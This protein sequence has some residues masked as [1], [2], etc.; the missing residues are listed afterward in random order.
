MSEILTIK[1]LSVSVGSKELLNIEQLTASAGEFIA[2]LGANGAGKTTLFKSITGEMRA[3]V[4]NSEPV[5][6]HRKGINQWSSI[7]LA[8]HMAVLPQASQLTFPFTVKE[9]VA[10]GLIPL[11]ASKQE[12]IRLIEDAML[13]TDT[14]QFSER[15]YTQLSGGERQRVHLARVLVQ[16]SQAEE[17]PLLLLDEPT[18]AQDLGQQH[19]IL[20]LAQTLC[21]EKGWTVIAILHDLNQAIRYCDQVWLLEQGRLMSEGAPEAVLTEDRIDQVWGYRPSILRSATGQTVLT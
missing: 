9:V 4:Q 20:K 13:K 7:E 2:L 15:I 19:Q 5:S 10:L 18:S 17:K 14:T 6:F 21:H 16:L 8:R 12:G 3:D 1:G 11:S